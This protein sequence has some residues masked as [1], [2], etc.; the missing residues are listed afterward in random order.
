M[1]NSFSSYLVILL[2][3]SS[4]F[5]DTN[6]NVIDSP[7]INGVHLLAFQSSESNQNLIRLRADSACKY[8]GFT[9]STDIQT[10]TLDDSDPLVKASGK[11]TIA[12]SVVLMEHFYSITLFDILGYPAQAMNQAEYLI[13]D[14][15]E[16]YRGSGLAVYNDDSNTTQIFQKITCN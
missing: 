15:V 10:R 5:A 14:V 6:K 13:D 12:G 9:K 1:K 4:A 11:T 7:N 16:G 2:V 3:G 8:Y